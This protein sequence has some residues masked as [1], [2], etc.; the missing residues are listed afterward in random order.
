MHII[1]YD[2]IFFTKKIGPKTAEKSA[3]DFVLKNL[4]DSQNEWIHKMRFSKSKYT[5][6]F[7]KFQWLVYSILRFLGKICKEIE[8]FKEI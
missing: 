3:L 5:H 8:G 2:V 6:E 4:L 1:T 7:N